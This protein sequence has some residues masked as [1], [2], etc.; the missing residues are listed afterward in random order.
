MA[1]VG[2]VYQKHLFLAVLKPQKPLRPIDSL[3]FMD[4]LKNT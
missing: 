4:P 2:F 1:I 3:P